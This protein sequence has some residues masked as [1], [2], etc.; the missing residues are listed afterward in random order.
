MSI[1]VN[2]VLA[3]LPLL[4]LDIESDGKVIHEAGWATASEHGHLAGEGRIRDFLGRLDEPENRQ[5]ILVG[6]NLR[7]WDLPILQKRFPELALADHELIDTLELQAGLTPIRQNLK[8]SSSHSPDKDARDA[9]ELFVSQLALGALAADARFDRVRQELS[10]LPLTEWRRRNQQLLR[11]ERI[12]PLTEEVVSAYRTSPPEDRPGLL[13]CPDHLLQDLASLLPAAVLAEGS[14][15]CIHPEASHADQPWIRDVSESGRSNHPRALNPWLVHNLHTMGA[16]DTRECT[17]CPITSCARH[18]QGAPLQLASWK[19]LLHPAVRKARRDV[20]SARTWLLADYPMS[21]LGVHE[22]KRLGSPLDVLQRLPHGWLMGLRPGHRLVGLREADLGSLGIDEH[23]PDAVHW[24]E[25]RLDGVT[26]IFAAPG[27]DALP[28]GEPERFFFT[29]QNVARH[30]IHSISEFVPTDLQP[31]ANPLGTLNPAAPARALYWEQFLLRLLVVIQKPSRT[32][33]LLQSAGERSAL[34]A[35]L[36]QLLPPD[37]SVVWDK[38]LSASLR[39]LAQ[40]NHSIA[41]VSAATHIDLARHGLQGITVI[42]EALPLERMLLLSEQSRSYIGRATDA[43]AD[44]KADLQSI[45]IEQEDVLQPAEED[46][47]EG[48]GADFSPSWTLSAASAAS[49]PWLRALCHA[50]RSAKA[51]RLLV[52]DPRV[53]AMPSVDPRLQIQTLSGEL[54]D[55]APLQKQVAACCREQFGPK[56]LAEDIS[57]E[58]L[59]QW[60]KHIESAFLA[61]KGADGGPGRLREQQLPYFE[62][63]IAGEHDVIVS[64][65]TGGGKSL[66]FQ[67]PALLKGAA[68]GRL[69]IV[70]APLKALMV[71]Q[72]RQLEELGFVNVVEAITGDLDRFER[73][74]IY[75]RLRSGELWMIYISPERLRSRAFRRALEERLR[76][77]GRAEYWIFDEAHCLSQ[78]GLD[79]RPDYFAAAHNIREIRRMEPGEQAPVL[80]FSATLT[81]Q[82]REEI[83]HIYG[84]HGPA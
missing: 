48:S 75:R 58:L 42:L 20:D 28:A 29:F 49:L 1:A 36:Q 81:S 73:E 30:V 77:D 70:I 82:V 46:P 15:L 37:V 25:R 83:K 69:S 52:M 66:I 33:L 21:Y 35:C 62:P 31:K 16:V 84:S 4:A 59:Q 9:L 57:Q 41:L 45:E 34:G 23:P 22:V 64:L 2:R 43:G 74:D 13:L 51:D 76:E 26:S 10:Q 24:L 67:G 61:G 63:V 8:L 53:E 60:Q 47:V 65:P 80:F 17:D 71:D 50:T 6:H 32:L 3:G 14:S 55:S 78:W 40:A 39:V 27:K 19:K 18:P 12:H 68:T 38:S 7:A 72:V 11:P 79:F 5:T 56:A 44:S 54:H